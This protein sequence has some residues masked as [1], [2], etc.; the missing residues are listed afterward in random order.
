ME[1]KIAVLDSLIEILKK[2]NAELEQQ[3]LEMLELLSELHDSAE[4]WSEY[5]VPI[6]IV[7]RIKEQLKKNGVLK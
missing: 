3:K 7:D 5:D 4:Y 1:N 2:E 6:G